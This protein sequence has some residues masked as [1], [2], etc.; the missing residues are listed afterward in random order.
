M[1]AIRGARAYTGKDK[2]LKMEGNYHGTYDPME[3]EVGGQMLPAGLPKSVE[4][5]VLV[6]RFNDKEAAEEIIR[7][8]KDELAAVIVEGIMGD[9]GF[10]FKVD[11]EEDFKQAVDFLNKWTGKNKMTIDEYTVDE[12]RFF[13]FAFSALVLFIL[14]LFLKHLHFFRDLL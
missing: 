1:F 9:R 4:K 8:N 5:D 14:V 6:T 3:P 11:T 2:I 7:E 10:S 13:Y 12:P